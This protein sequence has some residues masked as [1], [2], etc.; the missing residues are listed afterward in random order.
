M[1]QTEKSIQIQKKKLLI[2]YILLSAILCFTVGCPIVARYDLTEIQ[3]YLLGA[4][5]VTI[6][7]LYYIPKNHKL[8]NKLKQC[9]NNS[10]S[11]D[12]STD[13]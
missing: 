4:V 3:F 13:K 9:C 5:L 1:E 2:N 11:K 6:S 7:S 8:N 10:T 12:T